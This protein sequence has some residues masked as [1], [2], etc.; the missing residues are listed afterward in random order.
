MRQR[1]SGVSSGKAAARL[2]LEN[3]ARCRAAIY[4]VLAIESGAARLGEHCVAQRR[5]PWLRRRALSSER[6]TLMERT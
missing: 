6:P 4:P 1:R 5:L 2:T 3:L